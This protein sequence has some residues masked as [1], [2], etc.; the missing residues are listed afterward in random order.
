MIDYERIAHQLDK[1][2][3]AEHGQQVTTIIT[4]NEDP[5]FRNC[6]C[7]NFEEQLLARYQQLVE[8]AIDN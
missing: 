5:I 8:E 2:V 7:V 1:M 6:C 3:C 4:D